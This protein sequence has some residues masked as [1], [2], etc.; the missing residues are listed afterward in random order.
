MFNLYTFAI[1]IP[2]SVGHVISNNYIVENGAG[3]LVHATLTI[4][5]TAT[6]TATITIT[7]TVIHIVFY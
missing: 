3:M 4:T 2:G 1:T 5:V 7:V 6:V